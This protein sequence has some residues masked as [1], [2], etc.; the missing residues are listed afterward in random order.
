MLTFKNILTKIYNE[1]NCHGSGTAHWYVVTSVLLKPHHFVQAFE[2]IY[3]QTTLFKYVGYPESKFRWA[4]KKK[5][6]IYY[7]PCVLPFDVHTVH[8]FST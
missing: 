4:I 2:I 7:K 5:T 8:Y 6:R 1:E 3:S